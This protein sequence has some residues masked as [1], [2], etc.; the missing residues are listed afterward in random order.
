M[1]TAGV[2]AGS[3]RG[4]RSKR[5]PG[6]LPR[7]IPT[8]IFFTAASCWNATIISTTSLIP[9]ISKTWTQPENR[10]Y[11]GV[12][13]SIARRTPSDCPAGCLPRP[14]SPRGVGTGQL[15]HGLYGTM[16][17]GDSGGPAQSVL[18]PYRAGVRRLYG[19]HVRV[20]GDDVAADGRGHAACCGVRSRTRTHVRQAS[21]G[22][23]DSG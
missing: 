19:D 12:Y 2:M 11:D 4:R 14:Q 9:A 8:G 15:L 20:A 5:F 6:A 1:P 23:P 10:G 16:E 18:G 22:T 21:L 3:T 7:G 17:R 13:V